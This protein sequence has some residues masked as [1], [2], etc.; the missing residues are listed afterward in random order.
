VLSFANSFAAD[1]AKNLIV[2]AGLLLLSYVLHLV[3]F[4]GILEDQYV[5][6][7][8]KIDFAADLAVVLVLVADLL[9]RLVRAYWG[10]K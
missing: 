1:L 10:P 6:I 9:T 8:E 4:A 2:L 5:D 7:L 3:K